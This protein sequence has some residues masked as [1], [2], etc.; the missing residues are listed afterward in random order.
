MVF[1]FS[2]LVCLMSAVIS[3]KNNIDKLKK[4]RVKN[5]TTQ[6]TFLTRYNQINN[7]NNYLPCPQNVFS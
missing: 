6:K 1:L 5:T 7:L 3:Q 4:N 2:F